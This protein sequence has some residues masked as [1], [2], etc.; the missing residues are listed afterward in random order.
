MFFS[1]CKQSPIS[2]KL[3]DF[4]V[5]NRT[6]SIVDDKIGRFYRTT[7]SA[8]F[9]TTDDRFLLADFIGRHNN[10]NNNNNNKTTYKAP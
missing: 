3:A 10:N 9:C 4:I 2:K 7:K 5:E 1:H 6:C 8:D